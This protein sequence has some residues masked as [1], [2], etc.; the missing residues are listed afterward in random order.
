MENNSICSC[1]VVYYIYIWPTEHCMEGHKKSNKIRHFFNEAAVSC[2]SNGQGENYTMYGVT[3]LLIYNPHLWPSNSLPPLRP[4]CFECLAQNWRHVP[5]NRTQTNKQFWVWCASTNASERKP[6]F[7]CHGLISS[8]L[9][10]HCKNTKGHH[11]WLAKLKK[12]KSDDG[13]ICYTYHFQSLI[14]LF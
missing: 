14:G 5:D 8:A 7:A 12:L 11:E 13:F 1:P 2:I 3:F 6:S 9:P 10:H 4:C